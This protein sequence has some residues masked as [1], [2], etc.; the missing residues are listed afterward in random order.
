MRVCTNTVITVMFMNTYFLHKKNIMWKI[1]SSVLKQ[2]E[3]SA[4]WLLS[5]NCSTTT[6]I[7]KTSCLLIPDTFAYLKCSI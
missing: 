1:T 3:I 2:N 4:N 7:R 6:L 5:V